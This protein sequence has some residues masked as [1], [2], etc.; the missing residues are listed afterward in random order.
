MVVRLGDFRRKLN[1]GGA[2]AKNTASLLL[3]KLS[4]GEQGDRA[5]R[6]VEGPDQMAGPVS[7]TQYDF[8]AAASARTCHLRRL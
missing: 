1:S 3:P 8:L 4:H 7:Q 5:G 2:P 6:T